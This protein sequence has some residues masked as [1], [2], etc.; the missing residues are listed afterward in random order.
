M[1]A[2]WHD[3]AARKQ[4]ER[5]DR[6]PKKWRLPNERFQDNDSVLDVPRRCGLLSK[7][8]IR[9]TESYDASTLV[10]E[11]AAGRLSSLDVVTAFCKRAA[12]AQ[13]V[14]NC[15]TEIFF[16]DAIARAKHCDQYLREKGKPIGPLHGLPI[17]I[18]DSFKVKGYDASVGVAGFCFKPAA[19]NSALVDLL[20][21]AGAVLY[22]KTNVPLTM[23]ALDSHNNVFGRTLNAT[24]MKLTAGGSS[25]GEGALIAMRGSPLGIGTDVGGSIRIPAMC[26]GLVGVKPSH[27]RLPYVGQEGGAPP[28]SSKLGIESTAGPIARNAKDCEML[29]RV[30]GDSQPYMYDP[31][32]LPQTWA[33]QTSLQT[34]L[35]S[36]RVQQ[37][38]LVGIARTDGHVAPLPPIQRL[39]DDVSRCLRSPTL[40]SW[41]AIRVVDVD[42]SSFGPQILKV[43]NGIMSI[44][45]ANTWFN[46]TASTGEPMSPWLQ[47]RLKRRPAKPLDE[48][49]SLQSQRTELQ[50]RF[51]AIWHERGG[52]WQTP[53]DKTTAGGRMLDV[54]I[55]PAAPHP[56]PPIDRWNT[57]NYTSA[58]N[59]LD[60]PAGVLPVRTFD[61]ADLEGSVP[62]EAPLNGWDTIN[63]GLWN[64]VDRRLYVG[65]PLSVQIVAPR[66]M[67]RKLVE[68][69][70]MLEQALSPLKTL[71]ASASKL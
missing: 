10:A 65:S 32:V 55:C 45:G 3:I 33:Q 39:L 22:C 40:P 70:V 50:T 5:A 34:S 67:E 23:M 31:D 30:I 58:F 25:G 13:Q 42:I 7:Q 37:P 61:S 28:G 26:N 60:Y 54:I 51:Q 9:I 6:I 69:M 63:R 4:R 41:E 71:R 44:D 29:L 20:L 36:S 56:V 35:P 48:V 1:A 21:E 2:T 57:T 27:G 15:L 43:F 52:Y 59:L 66:L 16:E 49:R 68:I 46:H 18:K 24:N 11:L 38:L 62:N 53:A 19:A 64:D 14:V 47:T 17:S 8:D 12:I